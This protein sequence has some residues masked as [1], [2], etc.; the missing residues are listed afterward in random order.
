MATPFIQKKI[1]GFRVWWAAPPTTRDRGLA[2]LLGGLGFFWY[3]LLGR[4][5]VQTEVPLD[6]WLL[7]PVAAGVLLGVLLPKH[8]MAVCFPFA[9][10]GG[11]LSH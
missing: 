11:G 3:G 7:A 5:V 9:I 10:F 1:Q 2:A 6:W 8:T 4:F